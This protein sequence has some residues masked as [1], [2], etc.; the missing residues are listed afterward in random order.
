MPCRSPHDVRSPYPPP[1]P[2]TRAGALLPFIAFLRKLGAPVD[3]WLAAH[4]LSGHVL[5][6][7]EAL[8]PLLNACRFLED[9]ARR[10]GLPN[11]GLLVGQQ[12]PMARLGTFG[13]RVQNSMTLRE[14]LH[15]AEGLISSMNSGHRIRLETQGD[16]VWV[17]HEPTLEAVREYRQADA[18]GLALIASLVR[19]ASPAWRPSGVRLTGAPNRDLA[20]IGWLAAGS[21]QWGH[22]SHAIALPAHLL[23]QPLPAPRLAPGD[24][25]DTRVQWLQ[26]TAP[27]Q[28]LAR[29][30]RQFLLGRCQDGFPNLMDT[31]EAAGLGARTLQRRL[32]E[33]GCD[34]SRIVDQARFLRASELLQDSVLR[35]IDI[36]YHLGYDNPAN[37]TRAFRRW[38]G[39]TPLR[40][41]QMQGQQAGPEECLSAFYSRRS[42]PRG[43]TNG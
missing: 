4:R 36:A 43:S 2:L 8:I 37:F 18:F 24:T 23:M 21:P 15:T 10:E 32:L 42:L 6:D 22:A 38:T 7:P 31:A 40:Y 27:A 3:R 17:H 1:L 34:Y 14:A 5:D 35:I 41:R 33:Q 29:S 9:A 20:E 28:D 11:L 16:I 12:T 19:S 39:V 26:A 13:Q 30:V 25:P